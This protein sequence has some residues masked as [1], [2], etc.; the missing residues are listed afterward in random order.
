MV[1]R[2]VNALLYVTSV[3]LVTFY[4]DSHSNVPPIIS[5]VCVCVRVSVHTHSGHPPSFHVFKVFDCSIGQ[6]NKLSNLT[7]QAFPLHTFI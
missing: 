4:F 7:V 5:G 1:K 2:C 6:G 3:K